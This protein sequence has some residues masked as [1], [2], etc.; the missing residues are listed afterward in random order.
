LFQNA[1]KCLPGYHLAILFV[2]L[3]I[4]I[5]SN[6]LCI[7]FKNI[8]LLFL[9]I[10]FFGYAVIQNKYQTFKPVYLLLLGLLVFLIPFSYISNEAI[11]ASLLSVILIFIAGILISGLFSEID[12]GKLSDWILKIYN[13]LVMMIL[14]E[15]LLIFLGQTTLLA[16]F[17]GA[18][19]DGIRPYRVLHNRFGELTGIGLSGLNSI[20]IG[21]QFASV[22]LSQSIVVNFF[23]NHKNRYK[24]MIL[25]LS[26]FFMFPNGTGLLLMA[27]SF[28]M[29]LVLSKKVSITHITFLLISIFLFLVYI[30]KYY[31]GMLDF[32][33]LGNLE[34]VSEFDIMKLLF[35]MGPNYNSLF[36]NTEISFINYTALL[37]IIPFGLLILFIIYSA[38]NG[39]NK[40][41]T[42]NKPLF[43]SAGVN[44][45]IMLISLLHYDTIFGSGVVLLFLINIAI[46][47]IRINSEK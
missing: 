18:C 39:L 43:A 8:Y 34:I 44:L 10:F 5:A 20:F 27:F 46:L 14:I 38:Y 3:F 17:F 45:L 11:P 24:Y 22:I 40:L 30:E 15:A 2:G 12:Y 41:E 16:D 21:P 31:Y 47:N 13:F 33:V 23:S 9:I 42:Y 6:L 7:E 37:G 35:G 28:L 4:P 19:G 1:L 32:L 25:A 26:L 36:P 29:I